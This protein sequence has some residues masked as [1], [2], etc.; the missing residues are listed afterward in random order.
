MIELRNVSKT[1]GS[2]QVLAPLDWRL[3]PGRTH[4]LVGPS[5]CGKSTLLRLM[6]GLIEPSIGEI[7]FNGSRVARRDWP[8]LRR[9]MGYVIQDGGLFP[10]LTARQNVL[11]MA[12]EL[13]WTPSQCEDR[14]RE[15]TELTHFPYEA[16]LRYPIELSGGQR[17]RVGIMRALLLDP[18]VVLLDEPLGALDPLIRSNLQVELRSIFQSL[19]KTVVLVTHDV[20]EARF[21][22][23]EI[24][25]MR[26]GKMIQRGSFDE[27]INA[28]NDDY[29]TQ[30]LL[31]ER[32]HESDMGVTP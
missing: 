23:D 29:V 13:R 3:Q 30:F 16:T 9:R 24:A 6:V 17:Q 25:L 20:N 7:L 8:A 22:G 12:Q 15:L 27:L 32:N 28:P 5:G 21:F 11:L 4:V 26:R 31:A 1:Y 2:Q 19:G 10:H 14:L 18:D